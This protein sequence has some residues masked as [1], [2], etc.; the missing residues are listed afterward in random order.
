MIVYITKIEELKEY[1]RR[2]KTLFV[3]K[4][5]LEYVSGINANKTEI[6]TKRISFTENF[7]FE[8]IYGFAQ[9]FILLFLLQLSA[10]LNV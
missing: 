9:H 3:K 10:L 7:I 5:G 8:N 2:L 1:F 6:T 4:I